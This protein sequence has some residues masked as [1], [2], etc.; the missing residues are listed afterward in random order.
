MRARSRTLLE[1]ALQRAG[2]AVIAVENGSQA[3][4]ELVKQDAQR[5]ALLDWIIAETDGVEVCRE[6]RQRKEHAYTY[7]KRG[8]RC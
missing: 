8:Y 6:I 4:A 2:C 7:P 1:R 5:L 3:I